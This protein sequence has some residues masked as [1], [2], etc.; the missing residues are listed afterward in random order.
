MQITQDIG[1]PYMTSYELWRGDRFDIVAGEMVPLV[2]LAT[3]IKTVSTNSKTGWMV[4]VYIVRRD[5]SPQDAVNIG[6][7]SA[8]C[9]SCPLRW[10]T[11]KQAGGTVTIEGKATKC[12][13]VPM[14][15][16]TTWESWA[17]GN[18]PCIEPEEAGII[19]GKLGLPQRAGAYGDPAFAPTWVW[20]AIDRGIEKHRKRGIKRGTS[21]THQWRDCDPAMAEFAM[22]SVGSLEEAKEAWAAGWRTYRMTKP[23]EGPTKNELVCLFTTHNIQCADCGRC[24]GNRT[25]GK[26]ITV[27]AIMK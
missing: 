19:F 13:V 20:E 10:Y 16:S 15:L 24:D 26:S 3:C 1:M 23:D 5:M 2:V 4:Q 22:A 21:Y 7:D 11:V 14:F 17:K 12:Y 18:V 9:G 8:V 6:A 25:G 27:P